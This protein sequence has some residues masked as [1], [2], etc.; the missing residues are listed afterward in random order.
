MYPNLDLTLKKKADGKIVDD[1]W[2]GFEKK[3]YKDS[4]RLKLDKQNA[5]VGVKQKGPEQVLKRFNPIKSNMPISSAKKAAI[6]K[7]GFK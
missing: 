6:V 5:Y 7:I 2:T 1:R 3:M 4:S